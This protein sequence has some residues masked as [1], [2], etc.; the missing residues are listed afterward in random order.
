M[1]STDRRRLA[2]ILGMLGS[3][4]AGERAAAGL[5]AEAFRKRHGLTWE[6]MLTSPSP[7]WARPW[8]QS[9]Q[10]APQPP[11]A[12]PPPPPRP[13]APPTP[14]PYAHAP[15]W[16]KPDTRPPDPAWTRYMPE[17]MKAAIYV[18]GLIGG[19]VLINL[20]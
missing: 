12:P 20:L 5:Q 10:E 9:E 15:S 13:Q 19:T 6:Q 8:E 17:Q 18:I 11:P 4:H 7:S 14:D 16:A 3:D 2:A 1:T